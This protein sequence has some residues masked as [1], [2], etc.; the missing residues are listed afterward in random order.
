MSLAMW[1]SIGMA[2]AMSAG[3]PPTMAASVASSARLT[4][5][6]TGA[7][8][9]PMPRSARAAPSSRV[10]VGSQELISTISEPARRSAARPPSPSAASR[11]AP[12]LGSMVMTA[13]LAC[14]NARKD[15][16]TSPPCFVG[17]GPRSL[18]VQ[19][20]DLERVAGGSELRRH[21]PSHIADADEADAG[22]WSERRVVHL[23]HRRALR[24]RRGA[25]GEYRMA[26]SEWSVVSSGRMGAGE[27]GPPLIPAK[28]RIQER[29]PRAA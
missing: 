4:P 9:R 2:R 27:R 16:A 10:E 6:E 23:V 13:S 17:E 24:G 3:S 7:S 15:A 12:A 5:P 1:R 19:I 11:T 22:G 28:A 25:S 21:G 14:A 26:S 29:R 8:T 20:E 18:E